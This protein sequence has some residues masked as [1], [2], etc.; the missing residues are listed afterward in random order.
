MSGDTRAKFFYRATEP[1]YGENFK[2]RP[3]IH[4]PKW[5]CRLWLEVT[6]V[7]VERI[8]DISEEDAMTE[9]IEEHDGYFDNQLLCQ[10]AKGMNTTIDSP[11]VMFACLW[12]SIYLGSWERNDWVWVYEFKTTDKPENWTPSDGQLLGI[13]DRKSVV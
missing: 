9:G 13:S 5:A 12:D 11:R 8:Q 3:S 4:M 10:V 2:W 1:Q 7:R 6:A